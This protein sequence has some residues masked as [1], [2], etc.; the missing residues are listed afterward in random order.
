MQRFTIKERLVVLVSEPALAL[1]TVSGL[2]IHEAWR[3][4]A[5]LK[6][7][8]M[9]WQAYVATQRT[10]QHVQKMRNATLAVA[11]GLPV[12][13]LEGSER[14]TADR[15]QLI[16]LTTHEAF[17]SLHPL[18]KSWLRQ[19]DERLVRYQQAEPL[20]LREAL[21]QKSEDEVLSATLLQQLQRNG[22]GLL[23]TVGDEN[24]RGAH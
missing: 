15:Q 16:E 9:D 11:Y 2:K 10:L 23:T 18:F 6:S 8:Q 14:F 1:G 12:Q 13:P 5:Q 19:L 3:D 24:I 7:V 17:S 21:L 22:D 4:Y 20:S